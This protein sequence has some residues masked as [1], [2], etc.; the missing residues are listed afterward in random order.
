MQHLEDDMNDLFQRAAGQY[1]LDEGESDWNTITNRLREQGNSPVL[2]KKRFPFSSFRFVLIVMLLSAMAMLYPKRCLDPLLSLSGI[3][4]PGSASSFTVLVN[5]N[6]QHRIPAK[7][8]GHNN[9]APP[10]SKINN[11]VLTNRFKKAGNGLLHPG[12]IFQYFVEK[13]LPIT[14][15]EQS[16]VITNGNTINSDE[17]TATD[18]AVN[19]K[20]T[21]PPQEPVPAALSKTEEKEQATISAKPSPAEKKKRDNG[22]YA[23]AFTVTDASKVRSM[24][25][26][27]AGFGGGVLLGYNISNKLSV[28]ASVALQQKKYDTYGK[29]FSMDKIGSAMPAGMT[30]NQLKSTTSVTELSVNIRYKIIQQK[31]SVVYAAAGL[32]VYTVTKEKNAYNVS[33]NGNTEAMKAM[34]N[35]NNATLPAVAGFSAGYEYNIN[36]KMAIRIAPYLKIPLQGVGVGSVPVTSAGLHIGITRSLR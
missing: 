25:F 3:N 9:P 34:Y 20:R 15:A 32:S 28:E 11:V 35:D 10:F 8:S 4:G 14:I 16:G 22:W 5:S 31:R 24:P 7:E 26:K 33:L 19:Q 23:G 12:D 6:D 18:I 36:N 13:Q 1:H 17:I 2:G 27:N 21:D 29:D 30:I